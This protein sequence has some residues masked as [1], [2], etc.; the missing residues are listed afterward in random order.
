MFVRQFLAIQAKNWMINARTR[1]Y[2]RE[3]VSVLILS[4]FI[5]ISEH[6]DPNS[7]Q[8]PFYLGIAIT[9]YSRAIAVLW[10]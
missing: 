9:S 10:L 2:I 3:N 5:I 1:E 6:T 7:F 4:V 8:T